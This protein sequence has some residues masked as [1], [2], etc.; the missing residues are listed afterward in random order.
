MTPAELA[1]FNK[2]VAAKATATEQ[3]Q[4]ESKNNAPMTHLQKTELTQQASLK[5]MQLQQA[6]DKNDN[7][8]I[9]Q[10]EKALQTVAGTLEAELVQ[11]AANKVA[12]ETLAT[13]DDMLNKHKPTEQDEIHDAAHTAL[14]TI[15][16]NAT[17]EEKTKALTT[18]KEK[19]KLYEATNCGQLASSIL[20][21]V[22]TT[23]L[24][25]IAALT[26][27]LPVYAAVIAGVSLGVI[28][29]VSFFKA[30]KSNQQIA[31]QETRNLVTDKYN[32]AKKKSELTEEFFTRL[33]IS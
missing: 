25:I 26:G 1:Y 17:L 29:P 12:R 7:D 11:L 4:D 31:A 15:I 23:G 24:A 3:K 27:T 28:G 32:L 10:A 2:I 21:L 30:F 13:I 8:A 20:S 5:L 33:S 19:M 22:T 16:S 18:F 9:D 6:L 14:S